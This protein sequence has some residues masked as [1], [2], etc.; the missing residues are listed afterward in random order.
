MPLWTLSALALQPLT[1]SQLA[2]AYV[3]ARVEQDPGLA[4]QLNLPV[5]DKL[6]ARLPDQRPA[7]LQRLNAKVDAI[8]VRLAKINRAKLKGESRLLHVLLSDEIANQQG[9]RVCRKEYWDIS[10]YESWLAYLR[11]TAETG[12]VSTLTLRRAA[13]ERWRSFPSYVDREIANLEAGLASGYSVPA[14]VVSRVI[15]MV[16]GMTGEPPERSPFFAPAR[17]TDDLAF[18]QAMTD[19]I[20][21]AINPALERYR[22]YLAE[23]YAPKARTSLGVSALPR[24]SSST[25]RRLAVEPRSPTVRASAPS[26]TMTSRRRPVSRSTMLPRPKAEHSPSPSRRRERLRAASV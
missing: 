3:E 21:T 4:D 22:S 7:A 9:L 1:I 12:D 10:H 19:V 18:K 14:P 8:A 2:D 23:R 24:P 11:R 17:L 5:A 20:R 6:R 16:K 26:T 25:C 15:T 13:L